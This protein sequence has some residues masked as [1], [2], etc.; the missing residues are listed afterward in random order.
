MMSKYVKT[1]LYHK[2]SQKK[3]VTLVESI[4]SS[5]ADVAKSDLTSVKACLGVFFA[6]VQ[7]YI[8]MCILIMIGY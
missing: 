1:P 6:N 5:H 3:T 2:Y 8:K 4:S 7:K